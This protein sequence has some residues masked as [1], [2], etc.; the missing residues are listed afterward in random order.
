MISNTHLIKPLLTTCYYYYYYYYY[1]FMYSIIVIRYIITLSYWIYKSY[2]LHTPRTVKT[3]FVMN[4]TDLFR[5]FF[6]TTI[7]FF[8]SRFNCTHTTQSWSKR[9]HTNTIKPYTNN[10]IQ[11]HN[12]TPKCIRVDYYVCT[13]ALHVVL[14]SQN[15]I[16][17]LHCVYY[18]CV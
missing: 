11:L 15:T 4:T 17:L 13:Q 5:F 10:E 2:Y 1:V 8:K 7:K 16:R 3:N 12:R 6:Q 14:S 18:S 9:L